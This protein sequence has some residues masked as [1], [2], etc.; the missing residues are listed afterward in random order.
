[1]CHVAEKR[2][3]HGQLN[4]ALQMVDYARNHLHKQALA[5]I[6]SNLVAAGDWPAARRAFVDLLSGSDEPGFSRSERDRSLAKISIVLARQKLPEQARATVDWIASTDGGASK[7]EALRDLAVAFAESGDIGTA[8][9]LALEIGD[10]HS[11]DREIALGR[12]ALEWARHGDAPAAAI[13]ETLHGLSSFPWHQAIEALALLKLQNALG[14]IDEFRLYE[15]MFQF[16]WWE[17]R[18]HIDAIRSVALARSGD[19]QGALSLARGLSDRRV[20]ATFERLT[21]IARQQDNREALISAAEGLKSDADSATALTGIALGQIRSN[22]S[23]PEIKQ[24]LSMATSAIAR[25][26]ETH[27]EQYALVDLGVVRWVAGSPSVAKETWRAAYSLESLHYSGKRESTI[28]PLHEDDISVDIVRRLAAAGLC[29]EAVERIPRIEDVYKR[30][31]VLERMAPAFTPGGAFSREIVRVAQEV[32]LRRDAWV[33][34]MIDSLA[35][36]RDRES[37]KLLLTT[38]SQTV[39]S[40]YHLGGALAELYPDQAAAIGTLVRA[41]LAPR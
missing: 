19:L 4:E 11:Y 31:G 41:S 6:G 22:G 1:M 23:P 38:A 16:A 35:E 37:V 34:T 25:I 18:T 33:S 20:L 13:H 29:A 9:S 14:L 40:A 36:I 3:A 15:A 32:V 21:P 39:D 26:K 17:K 30:G 5:A 2:A 10:D 27:E 12:T 8:R 7:A 28:A 24:A